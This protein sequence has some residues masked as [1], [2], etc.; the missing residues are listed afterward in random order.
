MGV[1]DGAGAVIWGARS[2][3][4]STRAGGSIMG[5]YGVVLGCVA[6]KDT[7]EEV[8]RWRLRGSVGAGCRD[9]LLKFAS[10]CLPLVET[11]D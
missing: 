5:G 11:R 4:I 1:I 7:V 10:N 9:G 6:G 3:T 8:E 2:T